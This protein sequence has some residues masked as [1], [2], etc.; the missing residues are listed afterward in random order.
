MD[1]SITIETVAQALA[2]WKGLELAII[3]LDMTRDDIKRY[4]ND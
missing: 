4:I 3:G 2:L 1:I